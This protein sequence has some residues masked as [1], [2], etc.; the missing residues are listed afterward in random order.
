M[1]S[2]QTVFR[3][4][5]RLPID[6]ATRNPAL[7]LQTAG[8]SIIELAERVLEIDRFNNTYHSIDKSSNIDV[9]VQSAIKHLG[10]DFN[11]SQGDRERIPKTGPLLVTANHPFG[12]LDPLGMIQLIRERRTDL[13]II[14]N[15]LLATIP[16]IAPI[17]IFVDPQSDGKAARENFKAMLEAVNWLKN[18]GV[19]GVFPAG[20]V[21][22]L[23]L[24]QARVIERTWTVHIARLIRLGKAA[25]LPIYFHG[26]NSMLFHLSG[27]LHPMLRTVL[28]PRESLNRRG[29]AIPVVVG[30]P[31]PY[32]RLAEL[33][34]DQEMV[35]FLKQRTMMLAN[36]PSKPKMTATLTTH[37]T[38]PIA[39]AQSPAILSKEVEGLPTQQ[40]LMQVGDFQVYYASALQ[41]PT[42]LK[43]IG[44]L[45]E[46]TFREV[47]EGTGKAEDIEIFDSYY[48]HLFVWHTGRGE[49]VGA[50]RLGKTDEIFARFGK[51][52]LYTSTLFKFRPD[53]IKELDPALELGRSWVRKEYQKSSIALA[54]L[55]K[56]ICAYVLSHPRYHRLFGP[57]SLSNEYHKISHQLIVHFI[58]RNFYHH[59]FSR[60]LKS[61]RPFKSRLPIHVKNQLHLANIE[62]LSSLISDLEID[63]KGVPVLLKEYVKMGGKILGFNIDKDFGNVVDGL[64]M[65]DL[66]QTD[67][68]LLERYMGKGGTATF[69]AHH[70]IVETDYPAVKDN[71][72]AIA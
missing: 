41:I 7:F 54:L 59:D 15:R 6:E 1:S 51:S 45:R 22:S 29:G 55:W 20:E 19:I 34:S 37:S 32:R 21:A 53:L 26:T 57:V 70:G 35:N 63:G 69:L 5:P 13:K 71:Q 60:H 30:N 10:V 42:I 18:G 2:E 65:V 68:K 50:Y 52:G 11:I 49:L 27:L 33:V 39:T 25:A 46:L 4:S 9:F 43:E 14:T 28:L 56:G 44:R 61:L 16:E 31:I 67:T 12:I 48:V 8:N 40:R 24:R 3:I 23:D 72:F 64:I 58:H 47:G 38:L 17:C 62:D 66:L 36:R